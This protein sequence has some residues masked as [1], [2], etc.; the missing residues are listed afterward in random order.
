M[1]RNRTVYFSQESEEALDYVREKAGLNIS[2]SI[3][4]ALVCLA[5]DFGYGDKDEDTAEVPE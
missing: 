2:Q 4:R 1:G 3:S 5:L